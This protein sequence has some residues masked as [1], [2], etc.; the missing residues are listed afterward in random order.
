MDWTCRICLIENT[1]IVKDIS[2]YVSIIHKI[3]KIDLIQDDDLPSKICDDCV[4]DLI[5]AELL[6]DMLLECNTKF[7]KIKPEQFKDEMEDEE[8]EIEVEEDSKPTFIETIREED[9]EIDTKQIILDLNVTKTPQKKGTKSENKPQYVCH[10]CYEIVSNLEKHMK[11]DHPEDVLEFKCIECNIIYQKFSSFQ[12]HYYSRHRAPKAQIVCGE[13]GKHFRRKCL[14][15]THIESEHFGY[16]KF[17][18]DICNARFKTKFSMK[19]HL[20]SHTKEK[21]YQCEFCPKAYSHYS[22]WKN[23]HISHTGAWRYSC[24]VFIL[25]LFVSGIITIYASPKTICPERCVCRKAGGT[26][27]TTIESSS[28]TDGKSFENDADID[29]GWI[30]KCGG[31]DTNKILSIK[32]IQ[33]GEIETQIAH[34]DMSKNQISHL[35]YE[36]FIN[37]T[38][39]RKLDLSWNA[40]KEIAE[41]SFGEIPSLEKLKLK[42]NQIE[43]IESASLDGLHSLKLLDISMNPLAC[44]CNLLW[45]IPWATEKNVKLAQKPKCSS[46]MAFKDQF[47]SKLKIG[48]HLHCE[49]PLEKTVQLIPDTP[50]LIFEGDS[51]T[52]RCR[53]PIIA[54]SD[55]IKSEDLHSSKH[56]PVY[57]GWSDRII[58]PDSVQDIEF[59]NPEMIFASVIIELGPSSDSGLIDTIMRIPFATR[60]H[61]GTY[62]CRLRGDQSGLSKNVTVLVISNKT[63][64]CSPEITKSNKGIYSWPKTIRGTTVALP[65][66]YDDGNGGSAQNICNDKGTWEG[67]NVSTCPYVMETTRLLEQF[68]TVNLTE[69]RSSLVDTAKKLSNYTGTQIFL[70]QLMDP[71]DLVFLSKTIQNF[72]TFVHEESE[73]AKTLL[74]I[75]SHV[76]NLNRVIL[77]RA[78]AIDM[79]CN[80][81]INAVEKIGLINPLTVTENHAL[82]MFMIPSEKFHGITCTWIKYNQNMRSLDCVPPNNYHTIPFN[83][84][85]IEASIQLPTSMQ[86]HSTS[87][88][89]LLITVYRNSNL[90]PQNKTNIL[91]TSAV[92]GVTYKNLVGNLSEPIHIMLRPKPY[93]N[94]LSSPR[95][96]I[97][98]HENGVWTNQ[99][100]K[101]VQMSYV[102]GLFVFTCNRFGYYGLIQNVNYL[103]DFDDERSG[104]KFRL[105]PPGFYVGGFIL[106]ACL[107]INIITYVVAGNMIHMSRR[108]KHSLINTWIALSGLVFFFTVGIYQTENFDICQVFGIVLHYLCL[109]VLLWISVTFSQF[110]KRFSKPSRLPEEIAEARREKKPISGLYFTGWGIGLIIC[111]LSGAINMEEYATYHFCFMRLGPA[112]SAIF[113]P[114]LIILFYIVVT[115]VRIRFS[116]KVREISTHISEGTQMTENHDIDHEN[117]GIINRSVSMSTQRTAGDDMEHSIRTQIKSHVIVL[118]LILET[119]IMGAIAVA[120][121]FSDYLLYEE[122]IFS[123][124]YAISATILGLFILFFFG[125]TRSDVRLI[126]STINCNLKANRGYTCRP[127][128]MIMFT[129]SDYNTNG[130]LSA[131]GG[132]A[133][134]PISAPTVVYQANI[135]RSNSQCSKTRPVSITNGSMRKEENAAMNLVTMHR[136]QF[137]HNNNSVVGTG[138]MA[139]RMTINESETNNSEIFYNPNQSHVARKFFRK[140]KRLQKQN[141]IEIQRRQEM[142]GDNCSDISS[143]MGCPA[144]TIG[145]RRA[146]NYSE[147]LGSGSKINNT[148]INLNQKML[149]DSY[150]KDARNQFIVGQ[151]QGLSESEESEL[152]MNVCHD[153]LRLAGKKVNNIETNM[154]FY[155]SI[156]EEEQSPHE[157]GTLK[158]DDKQKRSP[159]VEIP[160]EEGCIGSPLKQVLNAQREAKERSGSPQYVNSPFRRAQEEQKSH[161]PTYFELEP[162]KS[163]CSDGLV[164]TLNSPISAMNTCGLPIMQK[165]H[166]GSLRSNDSLNDSLNTVMKLEKGEAYVSATYEITNHVTVKEGSTHIF[167]NHHGKDKCKSLSE[168]PTIHNNEELAYQETKTTSISCVN[169]LTDEIN[170]E[171]ITVNKI[172]NAIEVDLSHAVPAPPEFTGNNQDFSDYFNNMRFANRTPSPTT[173]SELYPN[174]I[175]SLQSQDYYAPQENE[176]NIIMAANLNFQISDDEDNDSLE[177]ED[178]NC[179][180]DF[181]LNHQDSDILNESGSIDELYQQIKCNSNWRRKDDDEDLINENSASASETSS[182]SYQNVHHDDRINDN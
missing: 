74:D 129:K 133:G 68:S 150:N 165:S 90:F 85:I 128:N 119:W 95:P 77:Q 151:Q 98:D 118:L 93:H 28:G 59:H 96:V 13:C 141:N 67:L 137:V 31:T 171:P 41:T 178:G 14:L 66:Q 91:I 30:V 106:F 55:H 6:I 179:S 88:D 116:I 61:S 92:I 161:E 24:E 4:N 50:Q 148:N 175:V 145:I 164:L 173:F 172:L 53:A 86:L 20:R 138:T 32:E 16:K 49:S 64:Y 174:S 126:W 166:S 121:P 155:S 147:M 70:G 89:N 39:L 12:N 8:I 23:H 57:W 10:R 157:T 103:N 54:A 3:A 181:L 120:R 170:E 101:P 40:L 152:F 112:I 143:V 29:S 109:S 38:S 46:P 135:S 34:L 65:C 139:S 69:A 142:I 167:D 73:L 136:Q 159:L 107:W 78:Q 140:Q 15:I 146:Q 162:P 25:L 180:Q 5:N 71:M 81:F 43:Q 42:N 75:I 94:E 72:L 44:D 17:V 177:N 26:T 105:S 144:T 111:G 122:E 114:T 48:E 182:R 63:Q 45:L 82:D 22:D 117:N 11:S 113:V 123:V 19:L 160:E 83:E 100:C 153:G 168:L 27:T 62:D 21:P 80:K 35:D 7:S 108:I 36:N 134:T 125:I 58:S 2:D 56:I 51:L 99:G 76:M 127:A 154:G 60:N 176:L 97:W 79:T 84:R 124:I 37:M 102:A 131:G 156:P 104:Q 18:C 132:V 1:S 47:L 33:F 52:L 115:V 87:N 130:N 169:L 149:H 9:L 158:M 163:G 110:L